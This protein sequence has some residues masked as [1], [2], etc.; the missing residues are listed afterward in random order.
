MA[1]VAQNKYADAA[2]TFTGINQANPA[3]ARVVRLWGYFAK[4]KANPSTAAAN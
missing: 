4:Q 1:Q 3:S 2:Q